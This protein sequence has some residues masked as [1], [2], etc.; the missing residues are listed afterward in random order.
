LVVGGTGSDY[1][2]G[3]GGADIFRFEAADLVAGDIDTVLMGFRAAAPC[4]AHA[5]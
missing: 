1:L 4:P 2:W 5:R 3:A